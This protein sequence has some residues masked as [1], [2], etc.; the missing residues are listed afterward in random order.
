MP[1]MWH[2]RESPLAEGGLPPL[3]SLSSFWMFMP[4][5]D[6]TYNGTH[7][8][9]NLFLR[10]VLEVATITG[11]LS[12]HPIRCR[13]VGTMFAWHQ[14]TQETALASVI[15]LPV[16]HLSP[17]KRALS[18]LVVQIEGRR[19]LYV[20][21]LSAD[22]CC[23]RTVRVVVCGGWSMEWRPRLSKIPRAP[24]TTP[25]PRS[26]AFGSAVPW[27]ATRGNGTRANLVVDTCYDDDELTTIPRRMAIVAIVAMTRPSPE[28]RVGR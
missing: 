6:D 18:R 3:A 7:V 2:D 1:Y 5:S 8:I 16:R 4:P 19:Y 26:F 10:I 28:R 22:Y 15:D 14:E 24:R 13:M 27:R 21:T 23:V 25:S 9:L 11:G 12:Q 20:Y 17:C